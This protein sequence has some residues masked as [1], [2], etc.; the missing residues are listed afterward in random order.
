METAVPPP[1]LTP[2]PPTP[3]LGVTEISVT[4]TAVPNLACIVNPG[5][6]TFVWQETQLFS[7]SCNQF[8][9]SSLNDGDAVIIL[10]ATPRSALGPDQFCQAN[11]FIEIQSAVDTAVTGW[12]LV[13]NV[14]ITTPEQG[15]PP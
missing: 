6:F 10:D 9:Q 7:E 1:T 13:N 14:Q 2:P 5:A 8:A 11:E 15:C 12:V 3:E 4:E